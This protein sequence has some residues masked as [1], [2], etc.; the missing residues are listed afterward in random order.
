MIRDIR[1]RAFGVAFAYCL[2]PI[3]Y[4]L[5]PIAYCLSPIPYWVLR[6]KSFARLSHDGT[7]VKTR[8]MIVVD[9]S[10]LVLGLIVALFHRPIADFMLEREHALASFFRNRGVYLPEPPS[11][12]TCQNVYFGLEFLSAC[13][14]LRASG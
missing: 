12:A 10:R 8:F 4:R 7:I 14:R 5:L 1:G 3:A 9:F 11:E 2:L 6:I 13:F